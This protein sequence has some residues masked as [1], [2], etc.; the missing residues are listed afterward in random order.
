MQL[1]DWPDAIGHTPLA[2]S[3]AVADLLTELAAGKLSTHSETAAQHVFNLLIEHEAYGVFV[4]AFEA[5][6]QIQ[7]HRAGRDPH[8]ESLFK[9]ELVLQL[10]AD[11]K[12]AFRAE[13][14]AAFEKLSVHKV[15]LELPPQQEEDA[16][17]TAQASSVGDGDGR[18]ESSDE[19]DAVAVPAA[20]SRCVAAMLKG[21][22]ETLDVRCALTDAHSVAEALK[23]SSLQCV[24]LG[25]NASDFKHIR[26][27]EEDLKSHGRLMAGLGGCASLQELRLAHPSLLELA[28]KLELLHAGAGSRLNTFRMTGVSVH[29]G[30]GTLAD[31]LTSTDPWVVALA[32]FKEISTIEMKVTSRFLDQ[33]IETVLWPLRGHPSLSRLS[34]V[35]EAWNLPVHHNV[36][37]LS[38]LSQHLA[39]CPALE[40]FSWN[41]GT[42]PENAAAQ[43]NNVDFSQAAGND[44]FGPIST[45][46]ANST[47]RLR[48]LKLGGL[49]MAPTDVM[50]LVTVL[51][52]NKS[53]RVLDLSECAMSINAYTAL[54]A[55]LLENTTLE[56]I[57]L[58]TNSAFYYL[59]A[60]GHCH[61]FKPDT[62]PLALDFQLADNP[63]IPLADA[64]EA[65]EVMA[66]LREQ[67]NPWA[68][69]ALID[70]R[71]RE[72]LAEKAY[73][74]LASD[75]AH[76]MAAVLG[77]GAGDFPSD[78]ARGVVERLGDERELRRVVRFS[79]VSTAVD[80]RVRRQDDQA[81]AVAPEVRRL[82]E[83]D[84]R[85]AVV[86]NLPS[87]P[88]EINTVY[89]D[90]TNVKL[91]EA[92]EKN[93]VE[94]ALRL[95]RAG[96]ID[97]KGA[98]AKASKSLAM[99]EALRTPIAESPTVTVTTT[100]ATVISSTAG[101]TPPR[102]STGAGSAR[103]QAA[104]AVPQDPSADR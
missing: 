44:P 9:S 48:L 102:A 84:N 101:V 21:G 78:A 52:H 82:V 13:M 83:K 3:D 4:A 47:C 94:E 16:G 39:A 46:L 55:A 36:G 72:A 58:P 26:L 10:P 14:E 96:A 79:E 89:A 49:V 54:M 23:T 81:K 35:G 85:D 11:W 95:R 34:L 17:P 65:E 12:P 25:S 56:K 93:D 87:A 2:S 61:G 88:L 50:E 90:G 67:L 63:Y 27:P 80:H 19:D 53:L 5:F 18:S 74:E 43:L 99:S 86:R 28:P 92:V 76:L 62:S 41:A 75:V 73:P 32:Q 77:R 8:G 69:Q 97:F 1:S 91:L 70:R 20:V 51:A 57:L 68:P 15:V 71:Q 33:V 37:V 38:Y 40:A 7:T 104:G 100:N 103:S 59:Q 98:A 31:M 42:V 22:V 45:L 64:K 29:V 66:P 24:E 60:G 30:V 6:N